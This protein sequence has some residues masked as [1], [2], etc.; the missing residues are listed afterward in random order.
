M[1]KN[2]KNKHEVEQFGKK[3]RKKKKKGGDPA[4]KPHPP[5]VAG[6]DG[7]PGRPKA[8][9]PNGH[10][11]GRDVVGIRPGSESQGFVVLDRDVPLGVTGFLRRVVDQD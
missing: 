8:K 10:E 6:N 2:K 7:V 4:V 9:F 1:R 11:V 5:V 3:I